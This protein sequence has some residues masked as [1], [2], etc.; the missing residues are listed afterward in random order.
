MK[1]HLLTPLLVAALGYGCAAP[2]KERMPL[3]FEP[4]V[5][6]RHGA[7]SAPSYYQLGRYYQGQNRLDMAEKAYLKAI[8]ADSRFTDAYNAL[9][10][11]YA[12]RGELERATL[13]FEKVTEMAPTAGYLHNNLGFAYYLQGRLADAYT[14]V[15][16]ALIAD[17]TL[18]R[19]WAN[20]EKIAGLYAEP[21]IVAA[22]KSKRLDALPVELV[23]QSPAEG[24]ATVRTQLAGDLPQPPELPLPNESASQTTPLPVTAGNDAVADIAGQMPALARSNDLPPAGEA[25][26]VIAVNA[27]RGPQPDAPKVGP[28]ET[29]CPG[30]MKARDASGAAVQVE[31]SNGNGVARFATNFSSRLRESNIPVAR[32]T[33]LES[34]TL[35]N[36]RVEYQP[37]FDGAACELMKRARLAASLAPAASPR[38]RSDVRIVLGRDAV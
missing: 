17:R 1:P 10:S 4:V 22:A 20:L 27:G 35:K 19:A 25:V 6:I 14:A 24:A 34:F 37:G 3:K 31:V 9:G 2:E 33:N 38:A 29:A 23:T 7:A 5:S 15:R 16:K 12:E 30:D 13:M 28:G 36:T 32:I 8:D 18:E 26:A 11:L 21:A